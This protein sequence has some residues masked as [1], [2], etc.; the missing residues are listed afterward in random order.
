MYLGVFIA[1]GLGAVIIGAASSWYI[2]SLS[3]WYDLQD[4]NRLQDLPSSYDIQ[5]CTTSTSIHAKT[6]FTV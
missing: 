4:N 5:H 1:L 6:T 2:L 3:T